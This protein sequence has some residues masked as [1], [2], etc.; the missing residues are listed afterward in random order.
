MRDAT[1]RNLDTIDAEIA[2]ANVRLAQLE[3]ERA[4]A[5]EAKR[6]AAIKAFDDGA[7]RAQIV[8][9]Y[10]ITYKALSAILHKAG[11]TEKQR[12]A[13]GLSPKQEA[14]YQRLTRG[15]VPSRTA[16]NIAVALAGSRGGDLQGARP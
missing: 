8:A 10:G 9:A 16:R 11:R 5:M 2:A 12:Q 4:E 13:L 7:R 15:G 14:E 1:P 6:C 3:I